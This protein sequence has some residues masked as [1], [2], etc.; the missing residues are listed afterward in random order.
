[1]KSTRGALGHSLLR[2]LARTAHSFACSALVVLLARS[3]ALIRSLARSW[4]K[5]FCLL[6][7]RIA[8]MSFEPTVRCQRVRLCNCTFSPS[9]IVTFPG[10]P[11]CDYTVCHPADEQDPSMQ[12]PDVPDVVS[13]WDERGK[14]GRSP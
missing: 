14:T 2:L 6:N 4:K 3:A 7:E 5:G 10:N 1:M 8:F 13:T 9:C 11:S 12:R